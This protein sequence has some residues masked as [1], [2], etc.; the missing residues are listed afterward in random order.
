MLN[1]AQERSLSAT[2]QIIED[3]AREMEVAMNGPYYI[4]D[5]INEA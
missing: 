5:R 4:R 2:F 1:E 3:R